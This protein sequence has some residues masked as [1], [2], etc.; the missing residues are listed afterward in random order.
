MNAEQPKL[1]D[2]AEHE[3]TFRGFVRVAAIAGI[4]TALILILLTTRI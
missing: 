3:R 1:T 2:L 4:V